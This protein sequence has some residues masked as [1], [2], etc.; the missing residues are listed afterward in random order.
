[1]TL[2]VQTSIE[3]TGEALVVVNDG[4]A[5][6]TAAMIDPVAD[7][8]AIDVSCQAELDAA[9]GLGKA[10]KGIEKQ[11]VTMF[12]D[13][14]GKAFASHR[15][16]CDLEN[17][18]LKPV[19]GAITRL[20]KIV[21]DYNRTIRLERERAE[22]LE[23]ARIEAEQEAAR[24]REEIARLERAAALEEKGLQNAA[25]AVL[26][27]AETVEV[28]EALPVIIEPQRGRTADMGSS[29]TRKVYS[30]E[31]KDMPSFVEWCV[32]NRR[33]DF[34][35]VKDIKVRSYI[36]DLEGKVIIEGVTIDVADVPV[37]K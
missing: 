33:F 11:I 20:R 7:A 9:V 28:P 19:Q 3:E 35:T 29:H 14:K 2:K 1:M 22:Q 16:V 32:V 15:A 36:K 25:N 26:L 4:I 24:E 10:L 23:R 27:S 34:L 21:G 17:T 37:F 12:A 5:D 13:S 31:V 30:F 18:F 6:L 8:N